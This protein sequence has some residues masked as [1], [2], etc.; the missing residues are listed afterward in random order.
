MKKILILS[1]FIV[2]CSYKLFAQE[3][4]SKQQMVD[5]MFEREEYAKC[6]PLYLELAAKSNPQLVALQRVADCYR[7]IND[8]RHAEEWYRDVTRYPKANSEN[9]YFYAEALLAN[10]KPKEARDQ[11]IK[12]YSLTNDT[13]TRVR[14]LADC[15]S[16]IKWA[17]EKSGYE[18]KPAERFD[19]N[20]SDWGLAFYG[21]DDFAFVSDRGSGSNGIYERTGAGYLQLYRATGNEIKPWLI[22]VKDNKFFNG[23]YN[24]GPIAFT[25]MGDTAY[26][27]VTTTVSKKSLPVHRGNMSGQGL[28]ERR[29]QLFTAVLKDNIW[30]DLTPFEYNNV[31]EYSVGHAALSLDG[32]TIYFTSDMPGGQGKTD[33]WFCKKQPDGKWSKPMNCGGI[34]N[35]KDEEAFPV[36][37]AGTLYYSSKG[38][39]GMG[40]FDIYKA[41]R[42]GDDWSKSENLKYPVNSTRDDFYFVTRDGL[43]GYLSSN[44]DDGRSDDIYSF[45]FTP[46][47]ANPHETGFAPGL[48]LANIYYDL[49]KSNI[50]PDAI[51]ELDK[52]VAILSRN[53]QI[54]VQLSSYTDS[55]ATKDYNVGLS[56]RRSAS[57]Q[58]YL[59]DHGI[60]PGRL[61]TASF[62]ENNLVNQCADEVTCTEAQHQLNRRTEITVLK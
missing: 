54:K 53:P 52:V 35:T 57:A 61:I 9:I 60:E 49:D 58:A 34:I 17:A 36:I 13:A 45:R 40:G 12:Y 56:E 21:K 5:R 3:Q 47:P 55:R 32:N 51:I 43:N 50:R 26:I 38:L 39:P 28:Y 6:L 62:G 27:T 33:I 31:K 24:I 48:V 42:S 16:A 10:N 25:A 29:L 4:L 15:D 37:N 2:G 1:L 41:E 23:S 18:V 11:Y 7:L 44:R 14:K 59:I 30:S 22:D 20:A 8:Y 46:P 19:S